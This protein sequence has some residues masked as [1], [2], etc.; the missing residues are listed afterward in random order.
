MYLSCP[1][2]SILSVP[3]KYPRKYIYIYIHIYIYTHTHTHTHTHLGYRH[4]KPPL[5]CFHCLQS[6]CLI[7]VKKD[8]GTDKGR[9]LNLLAPH[10]PTIILLSYTFWYTLQYMIYIIVCDH[11]NNAVKKLLGSYWRSKAARSGVKGKQWI[12]EQNPELCS[13]LYQKLILDK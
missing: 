2:I 8:E 7:L 4:K 10:L 12:G 5:E 3:E 11:Y 13:F 6:H 1:G 9:N